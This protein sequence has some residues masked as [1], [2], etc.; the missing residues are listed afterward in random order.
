MGTN[1]V[2]VLIAM[3]IVSVLSTF[4]TIIY[5]FSNS[6]YKTETA[7][8]S[9]V[10]DSVSVDAVFIRDESI[11]TKD[12][13]GVISYS[14]D[15]AAKLGIGSTI[16]KI[17][18][19]E[20]DVDIQSEIDILTKKVKLLKSVENP[21]TS[22]SAQ[23]SNIS[24]KI[25]DSYK[26]IIFSRERSNVSDILAGSSELSSLFNTYKI[27]TDSSVDFSAEIASY[28]AK[29]AELKSKQNPPLSV[30]ESD[31]SAYFIGYA[32]G[33]E[34]SLTTENIEL[35]TEDD[36]YS[37]NDSGPVKDG[38]IVGKLVSGYKWYAVGIIKSS[39]C[40][41]Q[42]GD[43]I[44]LRFSST[45]KE[46]AAM[47][48]S[49]RDMGN[50][51]VMISVS[52]EDFDSDF[53]Q[54]RKEN[55]QL[56]KGEY[57]GIKVSKSELRFNNVEVSETDES[58]NEYTTEENVSGVYILNGNEVEFRRL[59]IIFE[60]SDYVISGI[61]SDENYLKLYDS[62]ITEGVNANGN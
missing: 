42:A 29:I 39:D 18:E 1:T 19:S 28:N 50:G 11:L 34:S 24:D 48:E 49:I 15:D 41:F 9:T 16:A 21:G 56:I 13:D 2:R 25:T 10:S 59:N 7:V 33:Y 17:F 62:I 8:T 14:V 44:K 35:L 58:G 32:D 3:L 60:T 37:V 31:R 53:V 5:H 61:S 36:I 51:N 27:L 26:T 54:H 46:A 6:G 40:V 47:V 43:E 38:K 12:I 20:E 57:T 23:P 30:I 4:G 22:L 55:I 52:C 45:T